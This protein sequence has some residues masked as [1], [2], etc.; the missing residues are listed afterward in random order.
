MKILKFVF[1]AAKSL[2]PADL[3]QNPNLGFYTIFQYCLIWVFDLLGCYYR[4]T[5]HSGL[6]VGIE[7][8]EPAEL[9]ELNVSA[10]EVK[11]Q[12]QF[13]TWCRN[14]QVLKFFEFSSK[15]AYVKK[16]QLRACGDLLQVVILFALAW[17]DF[18][19]LVLE[20]DLWSIGIQ[21]RMVDEGGVSCCLELSV[22][23][24]DLLT[25]EVPV[26]K[27]HRTKDQKED[28][29]LVVTELLYLLK[30]KHVVVVEQGQSCHNLMPFVIGE[31]GLNCH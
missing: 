7:S 17:M 3:E 5:Y 1:T 9:D 6:V 12:K 14:A 18:H 16:K 28:P 26:L 2:R 31:Q 25:F 19:E 29:T 24:E 8:I 15:F 20:G 30:E 4:N 13:M 21:N 11:E 23:E 22:G 10:M 27:I